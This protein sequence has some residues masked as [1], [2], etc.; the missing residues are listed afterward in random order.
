L[1]EILF[2][3]EVNKCSKRYYNMR[4]KP[5][6]GLRLEFTQSDGKNRIM[7]VKAYTSIE[8]RSRNF[9]TSPE[10]RTP[11][12]RT[13]FGEGRLSVNSS[14]LMSPTQET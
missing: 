9:I 4:L 14:S 10:I 6:L 12:L 8:S 11:W 1:H 7:I 13:I 3:E 2:K 5:T